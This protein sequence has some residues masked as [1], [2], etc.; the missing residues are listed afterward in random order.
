MH[1][2]L[3][4]GTLHVHNADQEEQQADSSFDIKH[5]TLRNLVMVP[6][7]IIATD[8]LI[9]S[10][11]PS[12]NKNVGSR[13]DTIFN[14]PLFGHGQGCGSALVAIC[15]LTCK[16]SVLTKIFLCLHTTC[17]SEARAPVT[18]TPTATVDK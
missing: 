1:T 7:I 8:I 10:R 5:H 17:N 2:N 16:I 6:P 18:R 3:G 9:Q 15:K 12:S 11:L 14:E 4:F 13:K